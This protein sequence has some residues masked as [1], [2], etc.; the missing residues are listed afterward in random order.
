VP[1]L[2]VNRVVT[3]GH[4]AGG[5][6]ALWLAARPRVEGRPHPSAAVSLAGVCDLRQAWEAGLG[7]GAVEELL[8]GSPTHFPERF[9]AASPFARL[10]LGVPQLLVHGTAD[11]IVPPEQSRA[12]AEAARSAGDEV[13]LVEVEGAD[14]FDVVEP[15]HAA[16]ATVVERL[17]HLLGV[18]PASAPSRSSRE[19]RQPPGA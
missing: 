13:E 19:G 5:Q 2:D 15:A 17:P 11:E 9:A 16:W 3:L 8:E 7:E 18:K 12:Y 6:L 1:E 4:S 14:H 10:P